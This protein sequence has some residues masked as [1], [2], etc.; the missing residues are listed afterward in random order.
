[1][2]IDRNPAAQNPR[3]RSAFKLAPLAKATVDTRS[4]TEGGQ[5]FSDG[6]IQTRLSL[7]DGQTLRTNPVSTTF[8]HQKSLETPTFFP[9]SS[10]ERA[11]IF[12]LG[13]LDAQK[14]IVRLRR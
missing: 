8:S 10:P 2:I 1:M 3:H 14:L 7:T 9:S 6:P 5:D 13:R 11:I 4:A 12:D